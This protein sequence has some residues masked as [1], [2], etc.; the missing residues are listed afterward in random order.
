M[1]SKNTYCR[2]SVL[3]LRSAESGHHERKQIQKINS[4]YKKGTT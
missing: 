2:L 4:K 1:Q 3:P